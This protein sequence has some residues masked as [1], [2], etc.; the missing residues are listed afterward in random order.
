ML[1]G[2]GRFQ[3]RHCV[4]DAV[5]LFEPEL[6]V[7]LFIV[8]G[9]FKNRGDLIV[10]FL[11]GYT[12]KIGIFITGLRFSRKSICEILCGLAVFEINH[13]FLLDVGLMELFPF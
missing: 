2:G 8:G 6:G 10:A 11:A 5:Q 7:F 13:F 9:L 12:G 3:I 1:S 4:A